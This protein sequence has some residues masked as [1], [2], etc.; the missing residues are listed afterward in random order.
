MARTVADRPSPVTE[1]VNIRAVVARLSILDRFL[2]FWIVLA[3]ALGLAFGAL[4]PGLPGAHGNLR[5]HRGL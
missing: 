2:P 5:L 4:V 1:E 3:M